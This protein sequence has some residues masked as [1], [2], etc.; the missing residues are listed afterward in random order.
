M[1]NFKYYRARKNDTMFFQTVDAH[2]KRHRNEKKTKSCFLRWTMHNFGCYRARK[3]D[4]VLSRMV[5]T[6]F[7]TVSQR[8][9]NDIKFTRTVNAQFRWN[10]IKAKKNMTSCFLEWSTQY[11]KWFRNERKAPFLCTYIREVK[12]FLF[13]RF[14]CGPKFYRLY[15][16][17]DLVRFAFYHDT[18]WN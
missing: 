11:F 3:D 10:G 2:F 4:T 12:I 6:Q 9:K 15:L 16:C 5:G 14:I 17:I 7:Q 8:E 1:H 18:I 13:S